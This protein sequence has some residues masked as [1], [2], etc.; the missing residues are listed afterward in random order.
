MSKKKPDPAAELAE[1]MLQVLDSRR[2][3]EGEAPT[4]QQLG[5]LSDPSASPDLI[6]RAAKKKVFTARATAEKDAAGKP[7]LDE[8]VYFKGQ[9]P[10]REER[11][12]QRLL[13]V[14]EAQ[15]RLGEEAYPPTLRRL[16]ELCG[17]KGPETEIR[18]AASSPTLTGRAAVVA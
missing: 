11:L 17:R 2:S 15:R 7:S 4:L 9:A 6:V 1:R 5:E 12:A 14:L 3:F 16:A 8:P 18:K 10:K 13:S